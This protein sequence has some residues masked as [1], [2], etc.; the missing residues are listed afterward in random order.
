MK[1]CR[2]RGKIFILQCWRNQKLQR[3]KNQ[4]NILSAS[5]S[6]HPVELE[7]MKMAHDINMA[8]SVDKRKNLKIEQDL[9]RLLLDKEPTSDTLENSWS[10]NDSLQGLD[11]ETPQR[12][13][14]SLPFQTCP[15]D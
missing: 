13:V 15:D 12:D 8:V 5:N 10:A 6:Y 9:C 11:V 2:K 1:Q 3:N 14:N 4:S 7:A